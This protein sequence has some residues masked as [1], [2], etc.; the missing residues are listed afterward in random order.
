MP[1]EQ[2]KQDVIIIGAGLAGLCCARQL[3][4]HGISFVILEA[5]D[6]VG[7]RVR[8][9]VV[10]GF[11]L[12]RGF[13]VLLSSYPELRR[14]LN[15][16]ELQLQAFVSGA[17]VRY[18][19]RF[20]ELADPWRRPWMAVTSLFTHIGSVL[21][22]LRVAKLRS[23]S[24]AGSY[25]DRMRDPERTTLEHLEQLKFSSQMIDRF[26]RPFLGGIFLD[27]DLNT[28]SRMLNFVFRMFSIG[29]ACLP[30]QG[31]QAIPEQLASVIP[32]Q[33]LRLNESVVAISPGAVTLGSGQ[34]VTAPRIVLAVDGPSAQRLL[35]ASQANTRGRSVRCF[36]YSASHPPFREPIL[37]LNGDGQGP[38]NN[39]CVPT[40][41]SSDYAPFGASLI[42]VTVLDTCSGASI[43]VTEQQVRNQLKDWYG[44]QAETW[45]HLR[46]YSIAYALP[47]QTC[48][49][50]DQPQRP[51]RCG[52]GIY[53]CGDHRDNASIEG[54]MVSGRRAAEAI[55]ED[56]SI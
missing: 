50:L 27:A 20:Y 21:D 39:L 38:I 33:R 51:V 23:Q 29:R 26:L 10:D 11:R 37:V 44:A 5:A 53:V 40:N 54:A 4:T 55:I 41:V 15:L 28:S 22:K 52:E 14:W 8:T 17:R 12:D 34:Q 18:G 36:Y 35:P 31:M 47:D 9:D 56:L 1:V 48:P 45:R 42:S 3:Q 16:D 43:E 7:G 2:L 13:Q 49:A 24:L 19:G 25:A 32:K 46:T 30:A 6:A